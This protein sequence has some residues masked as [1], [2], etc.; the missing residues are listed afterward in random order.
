VWGIAAVE[1]G[2]VRLER[3]PI[4]NVFASGFG[5]AAGVSLAQMAKTKPHIN[6]T[7][8]KIKENFFIVCTS[9]A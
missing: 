9:Y 8:K 3:T 1:I 5:E 7:T 6:I 2:P 4:F